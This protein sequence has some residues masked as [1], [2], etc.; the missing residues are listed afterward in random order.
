MSA[1]VHLSC[2]CTQICDWGVALTLGLRVG[3]AKEDVLGTATCNLLFIS[4]DM[5]FM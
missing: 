2:A 5:L 3:G 4:V 1:C